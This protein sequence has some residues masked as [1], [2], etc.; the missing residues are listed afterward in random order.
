VVDKKGKILVKPSKDQLKCTVWR[1]SDDEFKVN[2][3]VGDP[4]DYIVRALVSH[5]KEYPEEYG[6]PTKAQVIARWNKES[7]RGW[8]W[9]ISRWVLGVTLLIE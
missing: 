1:P 4:P 3:T 7:G 5:V 2:D 6:N 8:N 9:G